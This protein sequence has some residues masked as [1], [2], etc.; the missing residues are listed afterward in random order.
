MSRGMIRRG[1]REEEE[2]EWLSPQKRAQWLVFGGCGWGREV[3]DHQ[4]RAKMACP[5]CSRKGGGY[6][7]RE[8]HPPVWGEKN[9]KKAG[10]PCMPHCCS[11]LLSW[12]S[13]AI[14]CVSCHV[15]PAF[16]LLWFFCSHRHV[17]HLCCVVAV[18]GRL[19]EWCGIVWWWLC[20]SGRVSE[21]H[22]GWGWWCWSKVV[23]VVG[24]RWCWYWWR[25]WCWW[26]VSSCQ[27]ECGRVGT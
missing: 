17:G 19:S 14:P 8:T 21:R 25:W 16:D 22:V 27:I 18:V 9:E 7:L 10:V 12:P 4:K 3:T 15:R 23:V 11:F 24:D 20:G 2:K 1:V 26:A 6:R 5:W 13:L